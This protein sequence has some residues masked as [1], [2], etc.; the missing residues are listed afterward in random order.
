LRSDLESRWL[1]LDHAIDEL[2]SRAHDEIM[3]FVT[4]AETSVARF[5]RD[6]A[7][8]RARQQIVDRND[9]G[10]GNG[11]DPKPSGG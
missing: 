8:A 1:D 7:H 6:V 2:M 3:Q 10:Q 5:E 4:F 9:K 11:S